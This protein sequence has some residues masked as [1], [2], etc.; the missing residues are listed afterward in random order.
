MGDWF[1]MAE[2]YETVA[3]ETKSKP[4]WL[5]PQGVSMPLC[6]A[7]FKLRNG[8]LAISKGPDVG[9]RGRLR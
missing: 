2:A 9:D 6:N 1:V 5:M 7:A 3:G 8:E 4:R